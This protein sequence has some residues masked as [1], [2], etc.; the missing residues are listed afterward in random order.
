MISAANLAVAPKPVHFGLTILFL[1]LA[2]CSR[3]GERAVKWS[4]LLVTAAVLSLVRPEF[5]LSL[6]ALSAYVGGRAVFKR[7]ARS[8]MAAAMAMAAPVVGLLYWWG[9]APLFNDKSIESFSEHFTLN[10]VS[11]TGFA[12]DP[13]TADY[14]T[15]VRNVFGDI[16]SIPQ[17]FFANPA[18]FLHH[19]LTNVMHMP[20]TLAQL[21]LGHYNILLP[22]FTIFTMAEAGVLGL[23][24]ASILSLRRNSVTPIP[25]P[26]PAS[27]GGLIGSARAWLSA[28]THAYPDAIPMACF[29]I[30]F[31]I[32]M[33]VLYPRYHYALGMGLIPIAFGLVVLGSRLRKATLDW[34]ML[35]AL[36]VLLLAIVPSL[37]SAS[38]SFTAHPGQTVVEPRP[39][40]ET[41]QFLRQLHPKS[42]VRMC[43]AGW[44]DPYL[45]DK[46][47]AVQQEQKRTGLARFMADEHI[48]ILV[49]DKR[50]R[51]DPRF[52]DDP[53]W[54]PF[55]KAPESLG[56]AAHK[57]PSG[58][59]V[60]VKD[61]PTIFGD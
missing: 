42:L 49:A 60:Y 12:G 8:R 11:W 30:P 25:M 58:T 38:P 48:S 4:I 2:L 3:L 23:A 54:A 46:F 39:N 40:L 20:T 28:F 5:L 13:H 18:V 61:D 21:F 52:A 57:L 41:V 29:L 53:E 59:V 51:S 56:F 10:Y 16:R 32:M 17:A 36:P 50:L 14:A 19:A 15:I 55:Q 44:M 31:P 45:S 24:L 37:G 9:G 27:G 1:S 47:E 33:T 35:L 26:R 43:Q 34:R 22:R 7:E 6:L